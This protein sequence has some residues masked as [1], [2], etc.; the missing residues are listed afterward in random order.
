MALSVLTPS[1]L[2]RGVMTIGNGHPRIMWDRVFRFRGRDSL[3]TTQSI[4]FGKMSVAA[5][6]SK[7]IRTGEASLP[8]KLLEG[9]LTS[10][11]APVIR[12]HKA[13]TEGTAA[14]VNPALPSFAG[15]L[16]DPQQNLLERIALEQRHLR[17][18][19][20]DTFE[21]QAAQSLFSGSVRIYYVDNTYTDISWGYTGNAIDS[22][23]SLNIQPALSGTT[24]W[25]ESTA[26]ILGDLET[27]GNQIMGETGYA[28]TF[29]VFL[30]ANVWPVLSANTTFMTQLDNKGLTTGNLELAKVM[31]YKGTIGSFNFWTYNRKVLDADGNA[32]ATLDADTICVIPA[33]DVEAFERHHA[34]VFDRPSPDA[35]VQWLPVEIFSKMERFEDPAADKLIVESRPLAV[36]KNV[37]A[38][39]IKKVLAAS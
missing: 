17:D 11:E 14:S 4:S 6:V 31:A 12:N 10:V 29:D 22:G 37:K 15:P 33:E 27:L 34:A 25:S 1:E 38:V 21:L 19:V 16:T 13:L 39:R 18:I 8:V 32:L 26:K 30:G 23:D 20:V 2:S 9:S 36:I 3:H 28:S 24:R 35:D 5:R 7:Y